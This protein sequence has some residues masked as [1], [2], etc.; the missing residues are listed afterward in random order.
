MTVVVGAAILD[1]S[2]LLAARR[3]EPPHL[4]GGW[5]LPGGKVEPDESDEEALLRECHEEL[6]VRI[7]LL[8][9]VGG[10]WPLGAGWTLRVWTA[11]VV[12]GVPRPLEDHSEV[13][14]LEPGKWHDVAWLAA[15]LPVIETVGRMLSSPGEAERSAGE[16]D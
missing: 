11:E 9:R 16:A 3:S 7:R 15:D 6:G 10:N 5:E 13:R 8:E 1:G 12:E 14:W 4:A 2:R